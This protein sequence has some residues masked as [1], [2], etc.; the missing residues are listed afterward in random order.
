MIERTYK[1]YSLDID[2]IKVVLAQRFNVDTENVD[3]HIDEYSND[4]GDHSVDLHCE[5]KVEEK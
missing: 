4:F 1:I 5:I 2:E 3:L